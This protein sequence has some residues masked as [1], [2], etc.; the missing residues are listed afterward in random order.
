MND[1]LLLATLL[2]GPKHGYALK[3]RAGLITGQPD[4]HN[5]L[6][7]PLLKR[8]MNKGWVTKRS[9]A[10]Q[11]GQTREVYALTAQGKH[12]IV[13]RL[14][15]F[16]AKEARDPDGFRL[17]VGLFAILPVET[18]KSILAQRDNL[19]A[20]EHEKLIH[21]QTALDVGKWGSEVVRFLLDQGRSERKW[22]TNL[23]RKVS[24]KQLSASHT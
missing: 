6:V 22:I 13:R 20:A 1:L 8:F 16:G 5:N 12:E 19:L 9:A 24:E 15:E 7:Y 21:L 3:K 11:R 23:Q 17:R 10:G 4:L 14:S 18:Q 2:D